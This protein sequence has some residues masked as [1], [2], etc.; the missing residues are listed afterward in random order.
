VDRRLD[1]VTEPIRA[2]YPEAHVIRR[3][4]GTSAPEMRTLALDRAGGDYI[5]ITEDHCVPHRSWLVS[6]DKA[7][8]VA[9]RSTAA[10]GGVIENGVRDRGLDWATF[11]CEYSAFVS[12]ARNGP[13]L[14]GS[15]PFRTLLDGIRRRKLRVLLLRGLTK[16]A[17]RL[18]SERSLAWPLRRTEYDGEIPS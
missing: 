1:H 9:P 10:V 6:M 8:Q 17:L 18:R 12:P 4:A 11:L 14:R 16:G 15:Y 3:A 2:D 7:F 13:A 5:A